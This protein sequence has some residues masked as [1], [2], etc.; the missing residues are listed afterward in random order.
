MRKH[1]LNEKLFCGLIVKIDGKTGENPSSSERE[2]L[3]LRPPEKVERAEVCADTRGSA[4]RAVV[5][6]HTCATFL[7]GRTGREDLTRCKGRLVT[8][9]G[10]YKAAAGTA[11]ALSTRSD[12]EPEG[13]TKEEEKEEERGNGRGEETSKSSPEHTGK[14]S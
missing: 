10:K 14:E 5:G 11:A 12:G 1:W 9:F 7:L 4:S 2:R 3:D 13:E 8:L 6:E